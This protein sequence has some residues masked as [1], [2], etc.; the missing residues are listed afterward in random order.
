MESSAWPLGREHICFPLGRNI[1]KLGPL[2]RE[3]S[4]PSFGAR[5]VD[6][7]WASVGSVSLLRRWTSQGRVSKTLCTGAVLWW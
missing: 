3:A 7:R 2:C 5:D 1:S 4:L 6:A